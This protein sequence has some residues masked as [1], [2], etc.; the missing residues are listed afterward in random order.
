MKKPTDFYGAPQPQGVVGSAPIYYIDQE[1]PKKH[2]PYVSSLAFVPGKGKRMLD[3]SEVRSVCRDFRVHELVAYACIMAW[4]GRNFSNYRASLNGNNA[5]KVINLVKQLRNRSQNRELDYEFTQK[6]ARDIRGLGISFYTKLLFFLRTKNDAYI[7]DQWTAKSAV[8][9]FPH[10]GIKLTSKGLPHPETKAKSYETFCKAIEGC[11]GV[12][13]WGKAW[14]NGEEVERTIFDRPRGPWRTW[15]KN[16]F[17]ESGNARAQPPTPPEPPSEFPTPPNPLGGGDRR[18]VFA[19]FLREVFLANI[20][21]G[22][23]LPEGCGGFNQPNRLHIISKGCV[24]WQFIINKYEIRAQIF[25]TANCVQYYDRIIVPQFN[26]E[27]VGER[28][29]FIGRI[30]GNGPGMGPTRAIDLPAVLTGGY[31]SPVSDWS[32]ICQSAV[33]AMNKL[34]EVFEA[35]LP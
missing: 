19:E 20:Y 9:L 27:V 4:G 34:F 28:H 8:V 30:Y 31:E 21:A 13:K 11:I 22:V 25:F 6:A 7:L 1:L 26:P 3:R 24:T 33:E 18:K 2:G 12:G 29:V 15:L 32:Y 16:Y 5:T 14:T 35:H 10:V 23:D 17:Q